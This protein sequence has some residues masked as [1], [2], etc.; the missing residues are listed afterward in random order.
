MT[1]KRYEALAF[2]LFL[3]TGLQG[4]YSINPSL[5]FK[6]SSTHKVPENFEDHIAL[7][8]KAPLQQLEIPDLEL[9]PG[10]SGSRS[11]SIFTRR[12]TIE[13]LAC[14]LS[15]E[16]RWLA[17]SV[18]PKIGEVTAQR[19]DKYISPERSGGCNSDNFNRLKLKIKKIRSY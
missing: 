2:L 6:H 14:T 5:I 17:F 18:A 1:W 19:L 8:I 7:A 11:A 9:I 12:N 15:A 3:L 10:I 16:R 13:D 4:L